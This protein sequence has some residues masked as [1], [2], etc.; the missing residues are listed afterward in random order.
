MPRYDNIRQ[1]NNN[2]P[3][4][5]KL[6]TPY[7]SNT[8]Y[9]TVPLLESDIYVITVFG[10][11]LDLLANEYYNSISLY[12][13]IAIANPNVVD[14]GSL[15]LPVGSQIRI[16]VDPLPTLLKFNQLNSL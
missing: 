3:N 6:G 16:P 12:W 8:Y 14:F 10:D 13:V 1:L 7:L 5:R 9:P 11:R 2:N 15:Y 4:F